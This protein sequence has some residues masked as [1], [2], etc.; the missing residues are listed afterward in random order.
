M[1]LD[2]PGELVNTA[3][4]FQDAGLSDAKDTAS[5]FYNGQPEWLSGNKGSFNSW[6]SD[7]HYLMNAGL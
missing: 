4:K 6:N 3:N 5:L 2:V 7:S 1:T